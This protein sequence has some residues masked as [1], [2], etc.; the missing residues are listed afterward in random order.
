MPTI[1]D[2]AM[3]ALGLVRRGS[4]ERRLDAEMRFHVDMLT[5]QHIRAGRSPSDARRAA[6][7]A[8]GGLER[9]KDDARDEYRSRLVDE[10][11]QDIRYAVRVI[12]RNPGFG[13]AAALTFALGIGASTAIFSVVHGVLLRPLPY[14][15]PDRLVVL[16]ER[17]PG[18][19]NDRNVV[20]VPNF[21]A[22]RSRARSFDGMAAATL[23]C[24]ACITITR[25]NLARLCPC[26]CAQAA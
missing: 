6:L 21:E 3:R 17:Q 22:W 9:F 10:L 25:S 14:K 15:D 16:W 7:A 4:M 12:R 1:R 5:E 26:V 19:G 23:S 8:F 2:V 20:S 24:F 13:V 11:G 18:R